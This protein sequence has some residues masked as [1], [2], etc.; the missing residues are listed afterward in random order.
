MAVPRILVTIVFIL[1]LIAIPSYL[2]YVERTKLMSVVNDLQQSLV[3]YY[4]KT[5]QFP[6]FEKNPDI[7]DQEFVDIQN[8]HFRINLSVLNKD[9]TDRYLQLQPYMNQ[10][11]IDWKCTFVGDIY[12]DEIPVMSDG[13]CQDS[14]LALEEHSLV[15]RTWNFMKRIWKFILGYVLFIGF[16][17]L[18]G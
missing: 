9:M 11:T 18:F 3:E 13:F 5:K 15:E 1:G 2:E 16:T 12:K 8:K 6:D 17:F 14:R 4:R 10:E 7:A